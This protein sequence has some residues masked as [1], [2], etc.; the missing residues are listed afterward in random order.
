MASHF[1]H[2]MSHLED[3]HLVANNQYAY[4]KS[5]STTAAAQ[6]VVDSII[7]GLDGK[8]KV[9]GVLGDLSKA[10][11]VVSHEVLLEKLCHYDVINK[12]TIS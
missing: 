10:I 1:S 3:N 6:A 11:D 5:G 9:A 7:T 2:L 12:H 8:C 4:W